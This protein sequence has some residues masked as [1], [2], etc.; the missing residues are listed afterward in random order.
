MLIG[1]KFAIPFLMLTHIF[2]IYISGTYVVSNF[3]PS[4]IVANPVIGYRLNAA[5]NITEPYLEYQCQFDTHITENFTYKISWIVNGQTVFNK[6]S[7]A[8]GIAENT[9]FR[10][11][12]VA[13]NLIIHAF[14]SHV[15]YITYHT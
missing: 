13:N 7:G 3:Q 10:E 14:V 11:G 12:T 9:A 5:T 1:Q 6:T 15:Q 2:D 4:S 8:A